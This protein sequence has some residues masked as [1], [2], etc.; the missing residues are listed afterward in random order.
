MGRDGGGLSCELYHPLLMP[1]CFSGTL[2]YAEAYRKIGFGICNRD[3][4][5]LSSLCSSC[6]LLLLVG[7]GLDGTSMP[8]RL[9]AACVL[10]L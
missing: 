7:V 2:F 1:F 6:N 8:S 10:L 5:L 9:T 4:D 3:R